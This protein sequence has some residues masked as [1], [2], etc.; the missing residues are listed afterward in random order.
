MN[1]KK[2]TKVPAKYLLFGIAYFPWVVCW[3][4]TSSY[5]KDIFHPYGVIDIWKY[6]GTIFLIVKL[7]LDKISNTA[8]FLGEV[9][10]IVLGALVSREK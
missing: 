6:V 9:I 5:Y 2:T 4:I 8:V 1:I 3:L 10:F 7:L